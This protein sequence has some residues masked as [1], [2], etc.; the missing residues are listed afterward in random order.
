VLARSLIRLV[1]RSDS[2]EPVIYCDALFFHNGYSPD[3]W[4]D[5]ASQAEALGAHMKVQARA[6]RR[7]RLF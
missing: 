7:R 6:P 5:I 4:R 3:L 2:F 1:I